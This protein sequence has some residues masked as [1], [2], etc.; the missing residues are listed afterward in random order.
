MFQTQTVGATYTAPKGRALNFTN[1]MLI[2]ENGGLNQN[3]TN[4]VLLSANN[5]ITDLTL[6]N[7]LQA[8]LNPTTGLLQG[9]FYNYSNRLT[10]SFHG[11]ILPTLTNGTGYFLLTNQSGRVFFGP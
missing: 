5:T 2:L 10:V 1:G 4:Q 7:H 3:L 8:T 11:A 6:S 9:S